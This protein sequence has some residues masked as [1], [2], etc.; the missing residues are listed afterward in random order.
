MAKRKEAAPTGPNEPWD[1]GVV[2]LRHTTNDKGHIEAHQCW[3][4]GNFILSQM[5]NCE[6]VNNKRE[7]GQPEVGVIIC[8]KGAYDGERFARA[9]GAR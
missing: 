7:K 6:A 5:D 3:N 1:P 2:Y 8:T 4:R 9:R